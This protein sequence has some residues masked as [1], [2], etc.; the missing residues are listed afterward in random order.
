MKHR[1]HFLTVFGASA[2]AL[3]MRHRMFAESSSVV[4]L[5]LL[6]DTHIHRDTKNEYRGFRPAENLAKVVSQVAD[7]D[8]QMSLLCGDAARLDGHMDDYVQLKSQL[9][10]LHNKM[11]VE[12]ALGNHDDRSNYW[13]V[14]EP[15]KAVEELKGKR[16]V[17]II[18]VGPQ[19]WIML[20]SLMFVDKTPGFLGQDQREWLSKTLGSDTSRPVVIMVHHTL[21]DRDGDLLDTDK[22]LSVIKRHPHVKAIIFGHSHQWKIVEESGLFLINL[23]AIGYNF[24]DDQPI[25]W[26]H[27]ELRSNGIKLT[28]NAIAG[29]T[30]EHRSSRELNWV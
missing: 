12:I 2:V 19:R 30:S 22:L 23:P 15:A 6:S 13:S 9:E 24:S 7:S 4:K 5:G 28:L 10:P 25:G 16:H 11:R 29:N 14:F 21:G 20:D 27:A 18:D 8:V 3:T 1:R 26:V 17:A